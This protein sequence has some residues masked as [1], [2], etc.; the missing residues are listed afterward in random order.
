MYNTNIIYMI[1]IL[2]SVHCRYVDVLHLE[3]VAGKYWWMMWLVCP[4]RH[5]YWSVLIVILHHIIVFIQKTLELFANIKTNNSFP[6]FS[7]EP[8]AWHHCNEFLFGNTIFCEKGVSDNN[9]S[10]LRFHY[11]YQFLH[12]YSGSLF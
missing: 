5:Q 8:K 10:R 7:G 6:L 2:I 9:L 3:Q 11:N 1:Y 4:A 12:T